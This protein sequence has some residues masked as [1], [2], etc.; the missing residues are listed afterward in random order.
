MYE[1]PSSLTTHF[2]A[3]ETRELRTKFAVHDP[4]HK[5]YISVDK[6]SK[7]IQELGEEATTTDIQKI[8]LENKLSN[9]GQ[10]SFSDFITV[11]FSIRKNA[12]SKQMKSMMGEKKGSAATMID[13]AAGAKHTFS[14]DEKV[15]F[16]EHLN[17]VLATDPVLSSLIPFDVFSDDLFQ[18]TN[19]G[20]VL[21]QLINL[22]VPDTIDERAINKAG[23]KPLN[24]YQKTE[25]LN[26][27]LN[28]ARAIGCQVVNIGAHDLLEGRPI[29]V[30]GLV[31]QIIKIQLMSSISIKN[32]PELVVL[33]NPGEDMAALLKL[34][35]D[36][37][38]L[39][40]F[41]YQLKNARSKKKISNFGKD[42]QDSEAYI[43]LLH[44]LNPT[45]CPI[46]RETE[47]ESKAAGVIANARALGAA[48]FIRP[49]DICSGNKKLNISFVAQ[50][51]NTCPNLFVA[52]DVIQTYDFAS[53]EID[54][55]GDSREERT[56]RM[57]MNSLN[58]EGLYVN[59]LFSSLE[60]GVAMLKLMDMIQPGIV[61]WKKV[62]VE[63]K[64]VFKKIENANYVVTL[65]KRMNLSLVNIGGTDITSGC[66][67]IILAIIGQL[68]RRYT[69]KVLS[70]LA[71]REGITDITDNNIMSWANNRVS[72][73]GKESSMK[74][75]R[76][77]SLSTGLFFLDLIAAIEPRAVNE[78][79]VTT[80]STP[81]EKISNAKY[82]ISTA[83]KIGAHVFLAPED[84]V[85]VQSKSLSTFL[86]SL[87]A[88]DLSYGE[89]ER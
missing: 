20:L 72:E 10:I 62:N 27:A 61:E 21:C 84:I 6:L 64:S 22:V 5:G 37:I 29:L 14:E 40:W 68:V 57:W 2:S 18:R 19:D 66:K 44:H 77:P 76:D 3:A 15:A 55:V 9:D 58:I 48:P 24:V 69:F 60:D 16:S 34:S 4:D 51:F 85:E 28:A 39:R 80:G 12:A 67:K 45:L 53:L 35:S 30:L 8:L 33:L 78:E 32:Y 79:L 71:V 52:E 38:L 59:N 88:T 56:F 63:P 36:E 25:N 83:R 7:L 11:T 41:N 47:R 86:A 43:T 31:W 89:R 23:A 70:E 13:G 82:V 1:I 75:F 74:S 49:A 65:G 54:D 87:W 17:N 50:L 42:L 26:L 46:V 73:S 81:E